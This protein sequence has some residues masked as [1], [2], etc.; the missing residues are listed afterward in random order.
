MIKKVLSY[1]KML[2]YNISRCN[3]EGKFLGGFSYGIFLF[4]FFIGSGFTA[5]KSSIWTYLC[6]GICWM[7][8]S[9]IENHSSRMLRMMPVS[10]KF[11]VANMMF[12]FPVRIGGLVVIVILGIWGILIT[13]IEGN[14]NWILVG[15]EINMA[16]CLFS[17]MIAAGIWF[18]CCL[19]AF[20]KNV[21]KRRI[22]Y[23]VEFAVY[24]GGIIILS[25]VMQHR[26]IYVDVTFADLTEVFP[27]VPT[28]IAGAAFAGIS[29]IIAWHCSL[30]LYRAD[31][32]GQEKSIDTQEKIDER[33]NRNMESALSKRGKRSRN[34]MIVMLVLLI[35]VLIFSIIGIFF[36]TGD[37]KKVN[38]ITSDPADYKNWN[39]YAKEIDIDDDLW[40]TGET[41]FPKD[42]DEEYI[43]EY[44]VKIDGKFCKAQWSS[45]SKLRFLAATL[46]EEEYRKEKERLANISVSC[47]DE[48]VENN[49]NYVLHDTENFNGEAYIA[50][51]ETG[52][53][54]EY[55]LTDDEKNQIV[56]LFAYDAEPGEIPTD[57]DF[58]AK[59]F[60]NVVPITRANTNGKGFSIYSF[61]DKDFNVWHEVSEL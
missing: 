19:G 56:Y 35:L 21:I 3:Q 45:I 47:D 58:D 27:W 48:E 24:V 16:G 8:A 42:M 18:W 54:Y 13:L 39:S 29:G 7:G 17:F 50:V 60:A 5:Y 25:E 22:W 20:H 32:K 28:L 4:I 43:D 15:N 26:K 1:Q 55:A 52:L 14:L 30:K 61:R 49:T 34:I 51:Y 36:G 6:L 9:V 44:Y 2:N 31:L 59:I 11:A 12:L 40:R 53:E 57:I 23:I 10:D 38:I 46:P 33:F 37:G 41:I